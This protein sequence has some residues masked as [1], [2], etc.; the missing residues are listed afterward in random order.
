MRDTAGSAPALAARYRK[1]RRGS[2][3]LNPPAR[4]TSLDHLVGAGEQG[5]WNFDADSFGGLQ[6]DDEF[7][8]GRLYYRQ[9]CRLLVLENATRIDP[10]L[11]DHVRRIGSVAHQPAGFGKITI[12][13]YGS[14]RM[15]RSQDGD[16]QATPVQ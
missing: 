7:E 13:E 15:A 10:D 4:F 16:L 8:F 11:A 12:G 9:V 14:H 3:I 2:F 6:I 1:F 5:R